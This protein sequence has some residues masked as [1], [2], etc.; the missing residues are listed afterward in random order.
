M[1]NVHGLVGYLWRLFASLASEGQTWVVVTLV[2]I[3]IG[4]N[5]AL[6]SIITVWLSDIKMGYCTT[7]WWLSRKFCCLELADEGE[8]CA[9]WRNWGGIE[10]FRY[11]A[12]VLF[13]ALF[14]LSAAHLVKAFAPYAAGSGISEIKCIIGGFIINGFLSPWTLAIKTLTLPL[15]IASGLSIGKEGPSVHVACCVG[16]VVSLCFRKYRESHRKSSPSC[17]LCCEADLHEHGQ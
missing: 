4:V 16:N 2:G 17:H 3:G 7:G 8:L 10:P 11:V 15:A 13:A 5:A 14:S 12:Y 6:I 9:E 1:R